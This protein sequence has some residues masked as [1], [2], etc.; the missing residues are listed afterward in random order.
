VSKKFHCVCVLVCVCVHVSMCVSNS[1]C[2]LVCAFVRVWVHMSAGVGVAVHACTFLRP[3]FWATEAMSGMQR[4]F[5]G[6]LARG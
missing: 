4:C 1:V 6:M 3:L 5:V 2:V